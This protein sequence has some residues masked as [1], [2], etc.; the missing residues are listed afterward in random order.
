MENEAVWS[1][2]LEIFVDVMDNPDVQI[3]EATTAANIEEWNSITHVMLIVA[4]EKKFGVKFTA[5]EVQKLGNV[6]NLAALIK[7]KLP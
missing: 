1:T 6:G 7:S 5:A 3:T 4:I 2:V